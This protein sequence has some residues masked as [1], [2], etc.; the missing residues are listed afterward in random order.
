MKKPWMKH[1][2]ALTGLLIAAPA[3]LLAENAGGSLSVDA[4]Q[5]LRTESAQRCDAF[6]RKQ[7]GQPFTPAP[8]KKDWNNR[9]DF[10]R[11]YV[12]SAVLFAT[13]AF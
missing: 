6:F 4:I 7:S 8:I 12:Q 9:G 11:L 5:K 10:T 2:I 13:R 3:A 1:F